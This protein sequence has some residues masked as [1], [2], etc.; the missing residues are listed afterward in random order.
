MRFETSVDIDATAERVWRVM[1]DVARWPEFTPTMTTVE[2]LGDG[3]LGLGGRFRIKQPG[4]P[5]MVWQV[6][7]FTDGRSFAWQATGGGVTTI[8]THVLTPRQSGVS[9]VLGIDQSGPLAPLMSLLVGGRT[10]RY[11]RTEAESLRRRCESG[12]AV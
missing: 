8:G 1:T 2:P 7:E 10:R 4:L 11:V 9:V 3:P 5:P 12:D 6:S